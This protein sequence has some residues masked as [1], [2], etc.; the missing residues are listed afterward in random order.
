ML[1]YELYFGEGSRYRLINVGYLASYSRG[2]LLFS[3]IAGI[4]I[5]EIVAAVRRGSIES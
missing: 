4:D 2:R 1:G 5:A 3:G